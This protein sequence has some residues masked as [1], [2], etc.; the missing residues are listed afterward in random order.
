MKG[1]PRGQ[2]GQRCGHVS[3]LAGDAAVMCR[4]SWATLRSCVALPAHEAPLDRP[5]ASG[6]ERAG[7]AGQNRI[8]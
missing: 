2:K 6:R 1:L 7:P 5:T 4:P 3:P 8:A